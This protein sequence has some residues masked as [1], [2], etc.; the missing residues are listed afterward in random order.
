MSSSDTKR[1][2]QVNLGGRAGGV[3]RRTVL[4]GLGVAMALPWLEAMSPGTM[5][6]AIAQAAGPGGGGSAAA[7]TRM[8]MIFAPNGVNYEHW[9]PTGTG[10]NFDLSPT[11]RPIESVREHIN[12]MTGLTLDKARAN[13]DGPGDH[14][15]SS[16]TYLTGA[17]AR[18]TNG[19]DIRIGVS[20]DQFAAQQIGTQSRLPSLEIGCESG[21]PAG[22]CDSG[23]SC[24]Y[25]SNI[26]WHDEDTP[27]PKTIDPAEVFE[28][29]FGD[30]EQAR[31][32]GERQRQQRRRGSVLDY[33]QE[34]T[35]R[36]ERRL[37][38]ADQ[39]KL[40]EFQTSIREI[41]RRIQLAQTADEAPVPPEGTQAPAGIPRE[42]GEHIDL[43]Y[44]MML[45]AFQMDITRI[46]TFMLGV[47]GSNRS[48]P[49][50]GVREGHHSLSHHRNNGGMI[51]K[52]RR[53]D[54]F[55]VE[56]FA[57]FIEKMA[58]VREGEGTLLDNSMILYGSGIS[59]GNRHNHHDLPVLLAGKAGGT[60][61]TGRL[62]QHR[63]DTPMCNLYMSMLDRM[64]CDVAE[65]G[66]ATGQLSGLTT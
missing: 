63:R 60:I 22:N 7:P 65:F 49:E 58:G 1:S 66:D 36:L 12:V 47:G 13:G 10:R 59:D 15:R 31:A 32:D 50:I 2:G 53:I 43:M 39:R 48:F 27:V 54:R 18:K 19:N 61:E 28:R 55:Y 38:A 20:V 45:L 42:V 57:K 56:H 62:I 34:D 44:D 41:E 8:A 33:V 29:L 23:Y 6:K 30:I 35:H 4:Q 40:D 37:G 3:S 14:A 16:A 17:Q 51:D 9:V 26:A 24:A 5:S 21:R 46:S 25:V 64:G 52:I 11:L